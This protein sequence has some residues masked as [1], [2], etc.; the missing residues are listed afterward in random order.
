MRGANSF[1]STQIKGFYAAPLGSFSA[2]VFHLVYFYS[3][4]PIRKILGLPIVL[5]GV[6]GLSDCGFFRDSANEPAARTAPITATVVDAGAFASFTP[7]QWLSLSLTR[8]KEG[9]YLESLAAAQTAA[10]L[11]PDYALAYNN[12]GAAY[13]Q[14]RLWDL[15]IQ[16]DLTALRYQPDFEHAR[17]N[18]AWAKEQKRLAAR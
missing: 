16:A 10:Y 13:G 5:L 12:I 1:L 4:I 2:A 3:M 11:R 14:L 18:L 17:N 7:E 9:K 15:A 8:Y 6:L